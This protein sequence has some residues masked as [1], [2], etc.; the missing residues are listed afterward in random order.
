[1]KRIPVE[2][3]APAAAL[4]RPLHHESGALL[5]SAGE[6]LGDD[7]ISL[8]KLAGITR[9]YE[10]EGDAPGAPAAP[11][12]PAASPNGG[13]TAPRE[14][15]NL[16]EE[17]RN[18]RRDRRG[19]AA[20]KAFERTLRA[21]LAD[22]RTIQD[23]RA[24]LRPD[25]VEKVAARSRQGESPEGV[26]LRQRVAGFRPEPPRTA[27]ERQ[28]GVE[29]RR[30]AVDAIAHA[31]AA[32][33]DP[34]GGPL[35]RPAATARAILLAA[36]RDPD[37]CLGLAAWPLDPGEMPLAVHAFN[38]AVYALAAGLELDYNADQLLELAETALL[39]DIGM[40]RLPAEVVDRQGPLSGAE[41]SEVETHPLKGLDVL[42]GF[43]DVPLALPGVVL[44][45]HERLDGSGYPRHVPADQIGEFARVV[46][47]A[48]VY[49]ALTGRRPYRA[50]ALDP[51]AA[52]RELVTL[53]AKRKLDARVVRALLKALSLFPV[54]SFIRLA[55]GRLGRVVRA[56]GPESSRPLVALL[57]GTNGSG[58]GYLDLAAQPDA[59]V[60]DTYSAAAGLPDDA[61]EIAAQDP[62]AGF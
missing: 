46:A 12:T 38:V 16:P 21:R 56:G 44:A 20:F 24:E 9:V 45:E 25:A 4:A 40:L 50:A 29:M 47:V 8:L 53:G 14:P 35:E 23:P 10:L 42:R 2:S 18:F 61:R 58:R 22:E 30:R 41:R 51:H 59:R 26:A 34:K 32:A 19:H 15:P 54:G 43:Q 28:A 33:R 27:R 17:V 57:S 36:A 11:G 1:M 39:H 60:A 3:L 49:E 5:F 55:D 62:L 37:L 13:A 7:E 6:R 31:F 52:L 48:D